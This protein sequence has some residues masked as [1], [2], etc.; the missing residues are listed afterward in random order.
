[1]GRKRKAGVLEDDSALVGGSNASLTSAPTLKR[2]RKVVSGL[3]TETK[4]AA[5]EKRAARI[6]TTCPQNIQER[7][8][9]VM[10]QRYSRSLIRRNHVQVD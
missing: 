6:R 4:T 9:R 3:T 1:M 10:S 2:A 7:V 5:P 8:A